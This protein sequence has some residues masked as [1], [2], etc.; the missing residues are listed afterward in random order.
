MNY[1]VGLLFSEDKKKIVLMLKNRP[2]FHAGLYNAPGGKVEA[3]EAPIQNVV[4][5]IYEET[6]IVTD[7]KDWEEVLVYP[8][9]EES[10][11]K[12]IY[13]Y[14]TVVDVNKAYTKEDQPVEVFDVN[15]LPENRVKNLSW[16]IDAA[17]TN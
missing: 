3:G 15:N 16:M 4:R 1:T 14:K 8:G 9:R 17:L 12:A 5:E 11:F 6:G 7:W 10:G 2:S 13:V